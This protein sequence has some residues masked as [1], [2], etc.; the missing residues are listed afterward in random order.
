MPDEDQLDAMTKI[1]GFGDKFRNL[2]G[3]SD[4]VI[5]MEKSIAAIQA[6][7]LQLIADKMPYS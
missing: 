6:M 5:V 4:R 1:L 2:Y 3:T 7:S